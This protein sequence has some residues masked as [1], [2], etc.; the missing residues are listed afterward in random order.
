MYL[1]KEN[2][3]FCDWHII[4]DSHKLGNKEHFLVQL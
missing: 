4:Y 1:N 3:P 2:V